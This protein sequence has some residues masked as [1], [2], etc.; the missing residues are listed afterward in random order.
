MIRDTADPEI[1]ER[2]L[3]MVRRCPTGRLAVAEP[4]RDEA[5]LEPTHD[6]SIAVGPVISED[7]RRKILNYVES[8]KSEGR[9]VA[10]GGPAGRVNMRRGQST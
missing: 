3:G 5:E 1:R 4:G 6:P 10:G 7:A 2:L 9:L 8:G